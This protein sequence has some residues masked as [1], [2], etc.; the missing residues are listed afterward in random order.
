M[1]KKRTEEMIVAYLECNRCGAESYSYDDN[2]DAVPEGWEYKTGI[3]LCPHC[4]SEFQEW[5]ARNDGINRFDYTNIDLLI[6]NIETLLAD[7]RGAS[8]QDEAMLNVARSYMED[9]RQYLGV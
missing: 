2:R 8:A 3:H 1:K 9:L 4:A 5:M 7:T 6:G